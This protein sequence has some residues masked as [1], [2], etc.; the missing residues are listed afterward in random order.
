[1]KL[2]PYY[3]QKPETVGRIIVKAAARR[4]RVEM[5]HVIN[6]VGYYA[7]IVRPVSSLISRLSNRLLAA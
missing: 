5:V 2:L 3:S 7:R 6:D 1:M 4:K